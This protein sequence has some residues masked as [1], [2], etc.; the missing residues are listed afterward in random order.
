MRF[1]ESS[2]FVFIIFAQQTLAVAT[3]NFKLAN[4]SGTL[5]VRIS[6][7]SRIINPTVT[8]RSL[9][10]IEVFYPDCKFSKIKSRE[11]LNL[12]IKVASFPLEGLEDTEDFRRSFE[13]TFY[14]VDKTDLNLIPFVAA[15]EG[16]ILR[17]VFSLPKYLATFNY[18]TDFDDGHYYL[19]FDDEQKAI[20][21]YEA[22]RFLVKIGAVDH[23]VVMPKHEKGEKVLF[24]SSWFAISSSK[25]FF[26]VYNKNEQ[27]VD[28]KF[29]MDSNLSR[30]EVFTSPVVFEAYAKLINN[31]EIA[32]KVW[33]SSV[34]AKRNI[35]KLALQYEILG[36]GISNRTEEEMNVKSIVRLVNESTTEL[37]DSDL[38]RSLIQTITDSNKRFIRNKVPTYDLNLGTLSNL[39]H[40]DIDERDVRNKNPLAFK[41]TQSKKGVEML[42]RVRSSDGL[43]IERQLTAET[44]RQYRIIKFYFI[45][46][47]TGLIES[48]Q[49][50]RGIRLNSPVFLEEDQCD[51]LNSEMMITKT[52][53]V[54]KTDQKNSKIFSDYGW[55]RD[56]NMRVIDFEFIELHQEFQENQ[57]CLNIFL[58]DSSK[59]MLATL[60]QNTGVKL[61]YHSYDQEYQP[62]KTI[63]ESQEITKF[64]TDASRLDVRFYMVTPHSQN[65]IVQLPMVALSTRN[66]YFISIKRDLRIILDKSSAIDLI[67]YSHQHLDFIIYSK[68]SFM[69]AATNPNNEL[70]VVYKNF[71]LPFQPKNPVHLA[72]T[73]FIY[74]N[75]E[76]NCEIL[77]SL[78]LRKRGKDLTGPVMLVNVFDRQMNIEKLEL[79]PNINRTVNFLSLVN[80][81]KGKLNRKELE[82]FFFNRNLVTCEKS[83][84]NLLKFTV[85]VNSITIH[86]NQ[87]D[88]EQEYLIDRFERFHELGFAS[89][90]GQEP[91]YLR[92]LSNRTPALLKDI[93][94]PFCVAKRG[95]IYDIDGSIREYFFGETSISSNLFNQ[96]QFKISQ[97]KELLTIEFAHK[98]DRIQMAITGKVIKLQATN[99]LTFSKNIDFIHYQASSQ[100][101]TYNDDD[102]EVHIL[103]DKLDSAIV[104]KNPWTVYS[105]LKFSPHNVKASNFQANFEVETNGENDFLKNLFQDLQARSIQINVS[106]FEGQNGKLHIVIINAILFDVIEVRDST[107][108]KIKRTMNN[109]MRSSSLSSRLNRSMQSSIRSSTNNEDQLIAGCGEFDDSSNALCL[110]DQ[111]DDIKLFKSDG[112]QHGFVVLSK[113][114]VEYFKGSEEQIEF[115]HLNPKNH[116]QGIPV[117]LEILEA[118]NSPINILI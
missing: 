20:N 23:V 59:L 95:I 86:D 30:F 51:F 103:I 26:F 36:L 46:H 58:Y 17:V 60:N 83:K 67:N 16:Q 48:L 49:M 54:R 98:P 99:G 79:L 24:S 61:H 25:G 102:I 72:Q 11:D 87:S 64:V 78:F 53:A 114:A 107:L 88:K 62:T 77:P 22:A 92:C 93:K 37:F 118:E 96:I 15:T 106:Y 109:L 19:A 1:I 101:K 28:F 90:Q 94:T 31:S 42:L 12:C 113:D 18:K 41:L 80:D 43:A 97:N 6:S 45:S 115:R 55:F 2:L 14:Q 39:I 117:K 33:D 4:E 3:V 85:S 44:H 35:C 63:I 9:T 71:V 66:S 40:F 73:K 108:F 65:N 69:H 104:R 5:R 52:H 34:F 76:N 91:E 10:R 7:N 105:Q 13:L 89:F 100:L 21:E 75:L 68:P 38:N 57:D 56:L 74:S 84:D 111:C 32:L 82:D 81:S 8:L 50:K 112:E 110:A 27:I 70:E 47:K 116:F 29:L